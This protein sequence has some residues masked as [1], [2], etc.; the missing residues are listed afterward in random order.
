MTKTVTVG[1]DTSPESHEA[2]RWAGRHVETTGGTL[3]VVTVWKAPVPP[4]DPSIR[5][6]R[7]PI[8]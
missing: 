7:K 3:Q 4:V 5:R 6:P 8:S 2:L 1:V